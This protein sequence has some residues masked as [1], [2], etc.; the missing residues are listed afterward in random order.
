MKT[1]HFFSL[2]KGFWM[3]T[4]WQVGGLAIAISLISNPGVVQAQ[5]A[6]TVELD[7]NGAVKAIPFERTQTTIYT[8]TQFYGNPYP[9]VGYP[10]NI[11][12]PYGYPPST[13]YSNPSGI[14][15]SILV[16]PTLSNTQIYNSTI[17]NPRRR[18][19]HA[20]PPHEV[21]YRYPA[22]NHINFPNIQYPQIQYPQSDR[23][24]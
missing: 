16:N 1:Q 20:L 6:Q 12:S 7:R 23:R 14:H 15:N 24:W 17:I 9:G 3:R 10:P 21:Q 8:H 19:G 18:R 2:T 22:S 4:G 13:L 11:Y 5:A